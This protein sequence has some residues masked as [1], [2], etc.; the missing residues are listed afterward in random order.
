METLI[1][2]YEEFERLIQGRLGRARH[3]ILNPASEVLVTEVP[4]SE[5]EDVKV[6]VEQ[7]RET[8]ADWGSLPVL[9]RS[10]LLHRSANIFEERL[11]AIA[12]LLTLEQGKPLRDSRKEL[13]FSLRCLRFYAEEA[14][15][16]EGVARTGESGKTLS[17]AFKVPIG[18]VAAIGPSNYPVELLMWKI[19]PA[20]AAG[21]T[22]VVKPPLE[23]PLAVTA[24]LACLQ[25]A[26]IPKGVLGLVIGG[27]EVG[28]ALAQHPDVRKIA[29]TGSTQVGRRIAALA[30]EGLKTVTLELGGNAPFIVC[31]DADLE[32]ALAGALRRSYSNAGQICIAAKRIL[33]E[34]SRYNEFVEAFIERAKRLKMA[35]GLAEPEADLGPLVSRARLELVKSQVESLVARGA[36]LLLGGQ[37]LEGPGFFY[38]PTALELSPARMREFDEEIFGPVVAVTP[39]AS[40]Q[41]ALELANATRYGLA[42]Y[43]YTRDLERAFWY[44]ECLEAGGIGVNVN[45]VSELTMPFG[46]LKDSGIGRELGKYALD[47]YLVLKHVRFGVKGKRR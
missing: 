22:V 38:P 44:A 43:V 6:A 2:N 17:L 36:R 33:V 24:T 23:T 1:P 7:A 37:R 28:E 39:F 46:G 42:A 35:D 5:L 11:E 10:K 32:D 8:L 21:C 18:V 45:D 25:E 31:A 30:G 41:E 12:R 29:F 16:L 13:L 14:L 4:L 19:A 20:L 15:R 34:D 40:D 26:G 27:A 47:N 3:P 9:E